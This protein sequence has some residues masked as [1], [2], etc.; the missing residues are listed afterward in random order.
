[1]SVLALA[2]AK[3]SPGATTA[4]LLLAASWPAPRRA[5]LVEA[6]PAGGDVAAWFQLTADPGLVSLIAA[7]RHSLDAASVPEHAQPLPGARPVDALLAPASS[8]QSTAALSAAR[9]RLGPA[10]AAVGPDVLL[11]CGRLD[12]GSP[13][14]DL[15]VEADLLVWVVRPTLGDVHHLANRIPTVRRTGPTAV[16]LVGDSPYG[17]ADVADAV[18]LP[19]VGV[20]ARDDRAA[21]ALRGEAGTRHLERSGLFRSARAVAESLSALVPAQVAS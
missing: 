18:G 2:S 14:T 9:G 15:A 12:A 1:M 7:G 19:A 6:D 10:L 4:A 17:A 13:S 20:L 3:G 8:E 5:L 16:L 21:A 11:D